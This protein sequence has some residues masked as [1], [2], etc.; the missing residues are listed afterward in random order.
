[1]SAELKPCPFCG[2]PVTIYYSSAE[3]SYFVTHYDEANSVC[4]L[5]MPISISNNHIIMNISGA[6]DLWNGKWGCGR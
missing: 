3:R 5:E 6:R 2:K 4:F 1:M